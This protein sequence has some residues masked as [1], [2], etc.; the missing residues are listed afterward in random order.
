MIKH[1]LGESNIKIGARETYIKDISKESSI[2]YEFLSK[3]HLQ[4]GVRSN[5]SIGLFI[6][7]TK[8]NF[9]KYEWSEEV[10]KEYNACNYNLNNNQLYI[11]PK[12][13]LVSLMTFG[14]P[15]FNKHYKWELL[16][17][18][19]LIDCSVVGS[20]YKLLNYFK[21]EFMLD[22]DKLLSYGNRRWTYK[23]NNFYENNGFE[24]LNISEPG[25]YYFK[26][27]EPENI[28][29]RVVFQKY[30]IKTYFEEN[31]Y[32]IDF[33]DPDMTAHDNMLLNGYRRIWDCGNFVFELEK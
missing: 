31:K 12:D 11:L 18:C 16:R 15:R 26:L 28:Y 30:K 33:F 29:H 7:K 10:I 2:V 6:K 19:N 25:Y 22:G 23:H 9:H 8:H 13:T 1:E 17:F 5:K 21:K 4:G 24:L 3:N 20:G 32:G 14:K 27:N